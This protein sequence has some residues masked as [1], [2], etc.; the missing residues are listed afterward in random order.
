MSPEFFEKLE[1]VHPQDIIEICSSSDWP[2]PSC[3]WTFKNELKP[4][5][6]YCYLGGRFGQPNGIQNFL[7]RDDSDNLVH[8]E[9]FL[10]TPGGYIMI[11]GMNFRTEVWI[12]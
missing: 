1:F 11:Q 7:R 6:I 10:R 4:V 8:W 3:Y 5:D 12:F 9:W 2:K